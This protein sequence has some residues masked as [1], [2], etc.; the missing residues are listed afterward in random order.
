MEEEKKDRNKRKREGEEN[1]EIKDKGDKRSNQ[2]IF[3]WWSI[4]EIYKNSCFCW[5]KDNETRNAPEK[6]IEKTTKEDEKGP[7]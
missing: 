3:T 7:R 2:P 6:K 4:K 5:E 1:K